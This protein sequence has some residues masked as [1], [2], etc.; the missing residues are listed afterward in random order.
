MKIIVGQEFTT[1]WYV[2]RSYFTSSKIYLGSAS[3]LKDALLMANNFAEIENL[4]IEFRTQTFLPDG[5]IVHHTK[6]LR[7]EADVLQAIL[8]H[9]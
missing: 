7:N 8:T 9:C 4:V 3:T 1:G 2:Y 5:E 6:Y